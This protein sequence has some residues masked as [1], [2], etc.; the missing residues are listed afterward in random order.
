M[1]AP[2]KAMDQRPP[3]PLLGTQ[4]AMNPVMSPDRVNHQWQ[5][6]AGGQSNLCTKP[7]QLVVKG[8]VQR[9]KTA[10][11]HPQAGRR[12]R[13]QQGFQV[14]Q[15]LR[16][17]LIDIPGVDTQAVPEAPPRVDTALYP[18]PVSLPD[19]RNNQ[20]PHTP[21]GGFLQLLFAHTVKPRKIE[22]T[23]G[24]DESHRRLQGCELPALLLPG[25]MELYVRIPLLG[26]V[27]VN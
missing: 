25:L 22:V 13:S 27:Q 19:T 12:C 7:G 16:P 2:R 23:V 20:T 18:S 24:I 1:V 21:G 26:Q 3:L 6:I 4:D 11:S 5:A 14:F 17:M 15:I 8:T 10:L 9:I